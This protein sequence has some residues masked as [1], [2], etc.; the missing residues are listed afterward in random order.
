MN[1]FGK[2]LIALIII[3][4]I[5]VVGS[6]IYQYYERLSRPPIE[7]SNPWPKY[8]QRIDTGAGNIPGEAKGK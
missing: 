4:C 8:D 5:G 2:V 7:I 1:E 6:S 3:A